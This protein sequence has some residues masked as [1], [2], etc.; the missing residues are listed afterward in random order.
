MEHRYRERS[1]AAL[2]SLINDLKRDEVSA[3]R[4]LG[5]ELVELQRVL[6][7]QADL[8]EAVVRRAVEI[9]PV[10]ERDFYPVRDDC[11]DGIRIMRS[12]ESLASS[13]TL[14]RGGRD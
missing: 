10:N 4:E 8:T 3:A 7:G 9:W 11:P 2:R 5:L 12:H 14:Q 6:N 13:R 1:G